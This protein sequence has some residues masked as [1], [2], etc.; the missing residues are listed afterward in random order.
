LIIELSQ[1]QRIVLS[2]PLGG[3]PVLRRF[4]NKQQ[5]AVESQ[6]RKGETSMKS[7]SLY[8]FAASLL[9]MCTAGKWD[10]YIASQRKI[11]K[12]AADSGSSILL[13]NE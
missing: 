7:Y 13:S 11:A 8:T 4:S 6:H 3:N 12:S 5:F 10:E 1:K 2:P 9:V